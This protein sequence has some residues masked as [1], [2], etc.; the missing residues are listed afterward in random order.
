MSDWRLS[1]T[2][3]DLIRRVLKSAEK[4]PVGLRL[5]AKAYVTGR[6]TRTNPEG[7]G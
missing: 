4:L 6:N 7:E 5:Q 1:E 3:D 2:A